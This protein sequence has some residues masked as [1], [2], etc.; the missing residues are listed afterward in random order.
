MKELS[1]VRYLRSGL[2]VLLF[3]AALI[4]ASC[5]SSRTGTG[6]IGP[7]DE[8]GEAAKL[9]AEA[10]QDLRKIKVLY[11]QNEGKRQELRAALEANNVADVKR[12][13]GEVV[14]LINEGTNFGT[15]AIDKIRQAQ[16]MQINKEY[17]EYLSLKETALTKQLEAFANYHQAARIL[18]DNY[19]PNDAKARERV[20]A[21]F[22]EL[23]DKYRTLM[24]QAR[25]SS[26]NANELYKETVNRRPN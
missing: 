19:D 17:M 2:L 9:V 4:A 6:L 23:T 7:V 22:D 16:D 11:D 15:S 21:E 8:T 10:N 1:K 3:S 5:G 18:R 12:I 14:Q 26:S 13:A 24:E 20:K 25:D